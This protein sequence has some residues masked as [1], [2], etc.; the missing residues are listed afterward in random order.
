MVDVGSSPAF[1]WFHG[2]SSFLEAMLAPVQITG[3]GDGHAFFKG[4]EVGVTLEFFGEG[5]TTSL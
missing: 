5:F 1:E 2:N 4:I 3:T